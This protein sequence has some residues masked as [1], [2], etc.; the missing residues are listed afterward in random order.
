EI[1]TINDPVTVSVATDVFKRAVSQT[2]IAASSDST[3]P[4]L[5]G[6]YI[7]SFEGQLYFVG[8]DGYRLGERRLGPT[9]SDVNS[10]VPATT[11]SEVLRVIPEGLDQIE[12]EFDESQV[13][14]KLGDI[15]VTSRLIDGAYPDYRKLIPE[16]TDI[17]VDI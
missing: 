15:E 8:T 16:K 2:V 1:P 17:T 6:I 7:H 3:R 4:I 11:M 5:T 9:D 14:F 10:V 13:H 12:M